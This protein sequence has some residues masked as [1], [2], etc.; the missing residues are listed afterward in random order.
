MAI[1]KKYYCSEHL[2]AEVAVVEP[3]Q[4]EGNSRICSVCNKPAI[5]IDRSEYDKL[6]VDTMQEK[7]RKSTESESLDT[8]SEDGKKSKVKLDEGTKAELNDLK[9]KIKTT[10][11]ELTKARE[12]K[13]IN[14]ESSA[15]MKVKELSRQLKDLREK[16][17]SL[18]GGE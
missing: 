16:K 18:K 13:K 10:I 14:P 4:N 3:A 12:D 17:E 9:E 6:V 8:F 5:L 11:T 2:T 15:K 1:I 7:V